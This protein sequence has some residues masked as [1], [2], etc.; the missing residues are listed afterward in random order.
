MAVDFQICAPQ[1]VIKLGQVRNIPGLPVRTLDIIGED[2]RSVDEVLIN[3]IPAPEVVVLSR[4]RL[5][6]QVPEALQ[7]SDVTSV[8]VLSTR[9]IITER[10]IIRF[11]ISRTP[12]KVRGILKLMQAFLKVLFTTPG[13]D[14]FAKKVGGGALRTIGHNFG[15]D[16]G[17]DIVSN[18][19]VSVDNTARQLIQVQSRN[20][21]LPPDERLL[22]AK[23]YKAGFV[24]NETALV[25]G[26]EILSQTGRVARPLLEL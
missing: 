14:I 20:S 3:D 25:V 5:L 15:K 2:F 13:T 17:A 19:I 22:S 11:R 24:K 21:S 1:E 4:T 7:N 18:F 9:L 26:I 10:S 16:Q 8:S 6:A 12:S 23:V